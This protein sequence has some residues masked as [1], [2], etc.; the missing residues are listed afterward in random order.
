MLT[1]LCSVLLFKVMGWKTDV[2]IPRGDKYVIAL[3]PHTCNFDFIVGLLY[4]RACGFKCDFLMKKEWFFWPLGILMRKLGG[5]PVFRKKKTSMTDHL[6]QVARERT[7][8]H[9]CVTPEGTRSR[10]EEWK[11]GFYYI[12]LKAGIPILLYGVDYP[13]KTIRCTKQIVPDGNFDRQMKEIKTYFKH[14]TGRHP[15]KFSTGSL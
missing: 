4:S 8:F 5:I 2:T 11:K 12:A 14:F 3:A 10:T 6:A 13:T 1:R 7:S 9:L 15:E